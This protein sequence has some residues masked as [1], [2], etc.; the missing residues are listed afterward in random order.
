MVVFKS[1]SNSVVAADGKHVKLRYRRLTKVYG[2]VRVNTLVFEF[3]SYINGL[4]HCSWAY[5][6]M[7]AINLS[8]SELTHVMCRWPFSRALKSGTIITG[9]RSLIGSAEPIMHGTELMAGPLNTRVGWACVWDEFGS[10]EVV[11]SMSIL[12]IMFPF[13]RFFASTRTE[14]TESSF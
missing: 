11:H 4:L 2:D 12:C 13:M 9:W 10:P 14:I 5:L 1:G 3:A 7:I 6:A 8:E